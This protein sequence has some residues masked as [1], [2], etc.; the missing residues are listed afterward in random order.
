M[1]I[2]NRS[3]KHWLMRAGVIPRY[4][5]HTFKGVWSLFLIRLV[6]LVEEAGSEE[7]VCE[8][9]ITLGSFGHGEQTC[10]PMIIMTRSVCVCVCRHSRHSGS[11]CGS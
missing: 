4:M 9:V 7:L 8:A 11:C 10:L 3:R 1:V 6:S 5:P 2:G